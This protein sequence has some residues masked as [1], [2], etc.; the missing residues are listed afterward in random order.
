MS[1][2]VA[3]P[4]LVAFLLASLRAAAFLVVAPPFSSKA[5]PPLVKGLLSMAF[6]LPVTSSLVVPGLG[7]DLA[8]M[9]GLALEQILVGAALGFLVLLAFAAIESAGNLIDVFGGF[10]LA[11]SFDPMMQS[12]N[13]VFG[14]LYQMLAVTLLFGLNL[15]VVVMAGFMRSFTAVP[16]TG[17]LSMASFSQIATHGVT[18]LVVAAAQIAGPLIGVLF[19]ADVGLALMTRVS[20]SMNVFS[21]GFPIKMVITLSLVGLTFPEVSRVLSTLVDSSAGIAAHLAGG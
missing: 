12:Q 19:L 14:R 1:L 16:L 21:L 17:H 20:P 3:T 8:Q 10:T 6:A 7:S 5:I 2:T 9:L 15:H 4:Y 13:S 18:T 11:S